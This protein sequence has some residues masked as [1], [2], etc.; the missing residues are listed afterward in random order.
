MKL[1]SLSLLVGLGSS[2]ALVQTGVMPCPCERFTSRSGLIECHGTSEPASGTLTGEYIDARD[3]T[4][5]GGA[6]HINGE[7]ESQGRS[8]LVAWRLDTGGTVVAAVE[9][10]ANLGRPNGGPMARRRAVL[11]VDGVQDS[12]VVRLAESAGLEVVASHAKV[13]SWQRSGDQFQ[14]G[15]EGLVELAGTALADRSCCTMPNLVWY[16]PLASAS[17]V[18]PIVGNPARCRFTGADGLVG[19]RYE[20]ANTALLGRF[21]LA[22]SAD[23]VLSGAA[24]DRATY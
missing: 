12:V 20:D 24:P 1:L 3:C 2:A 8:A 6:C 4:V 22:A 19:W 7:A 17:V 23:P 9:A 11:F 13:V 15:V 21:E 16:R 18:Q 5:F 10:D 14:V